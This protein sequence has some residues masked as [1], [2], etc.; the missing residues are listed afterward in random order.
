[1]NAAGAFSIDQAGRPLACVYPFNSVICLRHSSWNLRVWRAH[2]RS[3]LSMKRKNIP[4][5]WSVVDRETKVEMGSS[6]LDIWVQLLNGR[7]SAGWL[8]LSPGMFG[9]KPT[10]WMPKVRSLPIFLNNS[11]YGPRSDCA[12][13]IKGHIQ[14]PPES[15]AGV[16][17]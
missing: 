16:A 3:Q 6:P 9:Y 10:I 7:V 8:M 1:M 4:A 2:R 13:W 15:S 12:A 5:C 17:S 11:S 14:G